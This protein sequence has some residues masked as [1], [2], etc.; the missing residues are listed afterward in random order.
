MIRR[1]T[2]SET[3][4]SL[5][6]L[7]WDQKVWQKLIRLKDRRS[8][9]SD[10]KSRSNTYVE[11]NRDHSEFQNWK[12]KLYYICLVWEMHVYQYCKWTSIIFVKLPNMFSIEIFLIISSFDTNMCLRFQY[13]TWNWKEIDIELA[14]RKHVILWSILQNSVIKAITGQ[15]SNMTT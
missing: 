10:L 11:G 8:R 2:E 1:Q 6:C 4:W 3:A 9:K 13:R 12:P 14:L 5:W 7:S 15:K